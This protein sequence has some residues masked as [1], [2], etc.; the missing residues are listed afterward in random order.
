M[1]SDILCKTKLRYGV[2]HPAKMLITFDNKTHS[3]IEASIALDYRKDIEPTLMVHDDPPTEKGSYPGWR[4]MGIH[5]TV[6]NGKLP[7][8][9]YMNILLL[10]Y[11]WSDSLFLYIP[12][13]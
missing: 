4:E 9:D 3:F 8:M 5:Y 12:V 7:G 1:K 2:V 11:F 13:S 6:G 10:T